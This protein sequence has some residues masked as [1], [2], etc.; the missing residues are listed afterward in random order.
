MNTHNSSQPDNIK[1]VHVY[2]TDNIDQVEICL[3][4]LLKGN[5]YRKRK[6]FYQVYIDMIQKLISSC[7]ELSLKIKNRSKNFRRMLLLFNV[8][9][10]YLI[11]LLIHLFIGLGKLWLKIIK[12]IT[13]QLVWS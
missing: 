11:N 1:V 2:E 9:K 5:Q 12:K 3:K 7:D 4:G 13:I 6:D 10:W 8:T